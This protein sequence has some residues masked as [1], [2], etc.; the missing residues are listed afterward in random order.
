MKSSGLH[1]DVNVIP[2]LEQIY[3][4]LFRVESKINN[5]SNLLT[6]LPDQE[7]IHLRDAILAHLSGD[8]SLIDE[9]AKDHGGLNG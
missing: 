2:L 1:K 9:Y 5:L 4:R 7:R 8:R 6:G 3:Q